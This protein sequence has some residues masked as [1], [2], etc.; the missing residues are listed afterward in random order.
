MRTRTCSTSSPCAIRP[1]R[2]STSWT[3]AC[4]CPRRAPDPSG[5]RWAERVARYKD[6]RWSFPREE[7]VLL[8]WPTP[9]PN[10]SR[11]TSPVACEPPESAARR[12]PGACGHA[13]RGRG[14]LRPVGRGRMASRS[15]LS[16]RRSGGPCPVPGAGFAWGLAR[17]TLQRGGISSCKRP[18]LISRPPRPS[19]RTAASPGRFWMTSPTSARS[20]STSSSSAAPAAGDRSWVLVDAGI[21]G[22][23]GRIARGGR[24]AVRGAIAA[25]GHRPDPRPLRPRRGPARPGRGV[26]RPRL[27]PRA[28][29]A[30][31]DR[32]FAL[33]AARPDRRRRADGVAL[34]ALPE[35]PDR[36]GRPCPCS[37]RGR[38]RPGMPGWRWV[39]TPGPFRRATSRSS[40]T[41]TGP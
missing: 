14:E 19:R 11:T 30:L 32:P 34:V 33:P 40:A 31:P 7:C 12:A 28:G 10:C 2:S 17:R 21:H 25:L 26:G 6:R 1:R 20:S 4:S 22:S 38:V 13:G 37:P 9:R 36:P 18:L 23:A 5:R 8:P 39:H 27:R 15:D 3:T 29:I 24:E 41:P 35:G 16:P